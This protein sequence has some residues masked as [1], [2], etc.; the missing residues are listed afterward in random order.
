MNEDI[1][2][3]EIEKSKARKRRNNR[4]RLMRKRKNYWSGSLI[5]TKQIEDQDEK[6]RLGKLVDTPKRCSSACCGN[7]RKW[8]HQATIQEKRA[9]QD[10]ID[11]NEYEDYLML[12]YEIED[13]VE[14][15]EHPE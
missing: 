1:N 12:P 4:Y 10:K 11:L 2:W 13:Y 8:S 7:P 5:K 6:A 15:I 3:R 14:E 9:F